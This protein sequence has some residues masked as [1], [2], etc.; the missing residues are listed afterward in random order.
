MLV[1]DADGTAIGVITDRGLLTALLEL[2][3]P[4]P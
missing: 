4:S 2:H 3:R 1:V